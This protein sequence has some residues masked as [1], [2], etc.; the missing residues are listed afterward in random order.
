MEPV[1]H[2]WLTRMAKYDVVIIGA[3]PNGLALANYLTKAGAKVMLVEKRFDVGGSL[4][5]ED[6]AGSRYNLHA[7]YMPLGEKIPPY[8]DL[9]LSDY[10]CQFARPEAQATV[11]LDGSSLTLYTD[12]ERTQES[13][14]KV[15]VPDSKRFSEMMKAIDSAMAEVIIP[16][17]YSTPLPSEKFRERLSKKKSGKFLQKISKM[18]PLQ[19]IDHYGLETD[20][21][22]LALLVLGCTWGLDPAQE[23]SGI[24]FMSFLY[25]MLRASLVKGGS[26]LLASSLYKQ[27]IT[28]GMQILVGAEVSRIDVE[29]GVAKGVELSDGR[30]IAAKAVVSTVDVPSTFL[31]LLEA[32]YVSKAMM[33]SAMKWQWDPW[34]LFQAHWT[35]SGKPEFRSSEDGVEGSLVHIAGYRGVEDFLRSV[36][37]TYEGK[38]FPAGLLSLPSLIDPSQ[39]AKGMTVAKFTT[40]SPFRLSNASW[41][42]FKDEFAEQCFGVWSGITKNV[43]ESSIRWRYAYPPT[44]IEMKL[45]NAFRGSINGGAITPEQTGYLRPSSDC[46]S[47]RTPIKGVYVCGASV[48]PGGGVTLAGGY[49]ASLVIAKDLGLRVWWKPK[50]RP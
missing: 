14:S 45:S 38:P 39:A 18:S 33:S 7:L 29:R 40:I 4:L 21:L 25:G 48:H 3:G 50:Y 5:T 42:D 17:I 30:K 49:N 20:A 28:G 47:Y 35:V 27:A 12:N 31:K 2:S 1:H 10:G 8:S 41:D 23:D 36:S 46:S 37:G 32:G 11:H 16:W 6:F 19:V 13:I 24:A 44:Y 15:S 26:Y 22:R 43:T 34:S 9:G